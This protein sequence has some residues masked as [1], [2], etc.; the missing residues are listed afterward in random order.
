[1]D[2]AYD[3]A[4]LSHLDVSLRGMVDRSYDLC[5]YQCNE[6]RDAPMGPCKKACFQ[7]IIVPFRHS[8]HVAKDGEENAYRRCLANS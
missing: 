5:Q 6:V 1:M 8:N 3:K 4:A 2:S 7:N